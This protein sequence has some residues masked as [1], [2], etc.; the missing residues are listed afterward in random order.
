MKS[1]CYVLA[2]N[3]VLSAANPL[4][5]RNSS[6][7][8]QTQ[9]RKVKHTISRIFNI[10]NNQ[11]R[12][13]HDGVYYDQL[14]KMLTSESGGTLKLEERE[15]GTDLA[16]VDTLLNKIKGVY[17]ESE[18][19]NEIHIQTNK[20]VQTVDAESNIL[21]TKERK[22][23]ADI[24]N[25]IIQNLTAFNGS[26]LSGK[27]IR[28]GK[29]VIYYGQNENPSKNAI[30]INKNVGNS[31]LNFANIIRI[32]EAIHNLFIQHKV[33]EN[34]YY[35]VKARN[36]DAKDRIKNLIIAFVKF[37][38]SEGQLNS[39]IINKVKIMI[40]DNNIDI[41]L[42]KLLIKSNAD[43]GVIDLD[44]EPPT[45]AV[46]GVMKNIF[47]DSD[48]DSENNGQ[49]SDVTR[50]LDFA[51]INELKPG[52][53][54]PT[55]NLSVN[56]K[57]F[58][59]PT[60]ASKSLNT[61]RDNVHKDDSQEIIITKEGNSKLLIPSEVNTKDDVN[62]MDSNVTSN[63]NID[64][65]QKSTSDS[66]LGTILDYNLA[67]SKQDNRNHL[68][69]VGLQ[70]VK[71]P[72][73]SN[74]KDMTT[75]KD[76]LN[77]KKI[78]N[79]SLKTKVDFETLKTIL[80]KVM[81]NNIPFLQQVDPNVPVFSNI[82]VEEYLNY[83]NGKPF[84][85]YV[86]FPESE[87]SKISD[88]VHDSLIPTEK[89]NFYE[90][91]DGIKAIIRN[92]FE[93]YNSTPELSGEND[94]NSILHVIKDEIA[95]KKVEQD[96]KE[97][98]Q[99]T[100][101][102]ISPDI[103][104]DIIGKS[105]KTIGRHGQNKMQHPE[106]TEKEVIEY[107]IKKIYDTKMG[108]NKLN[109]QD[110]LDITE[111]ITQET[112]TDQQKKENDIYKQLLILFR[113]IGHST[114]GK[115]MEKDM[116]EK[117]KELLLKLKHSPD[118]DNTR[119]ITKDPNFFQKYLQAIA[120]HKSS[121]NEMDMTSEQERIYNLAEELVARL[122]YLQIELEK[123]NIS[124]QTQRELIKKEVEEEILKI[125]SDI[126]ASCVE[127]ANKLVELSIEKVLRKSIG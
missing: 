11:A 33:P 60:I 81:G 41:D 40:A 97:T 30:E 14:M 115:G 13:V 29:L 98:N 88:P 117:L 22:L 65:A 107:I 85:I 96:I 25:E 5:A 104:I 80:N 109:N 125:N 79:H 12:T 36:V 15:T 70:V 51:V 116:F 9:S 20:N 126:I 28:N 77:K 120:K 53:E 75:S 31:R 45:N 44:T 93:S 57:V 62:A 67:K 91:A 66:V 55:V 89:D 87:K 69:A 39:D 52:K 7:E 54:T 122:K 121:A 95:N 101:D 110:N 26:N 16:D 8:S 112:D 61:L 17:P 43:V 127:R 3:V 72:I 59:D 103:I 35:A 86:V 48:V 111:T 102:N 58:T 114:I 64:E 34:I 2:I 19:Q 100:P 99:G 21:G 27:Q 4:D 18:S 84:L 108:E 47:V 10:P 37:I 78:Q 124:R 118:D 32:E 113:N 1:L 68:K 119:S 46:S 83:N 63:K 6:D 73:S 82:P 23:N 56:A 90:V 105:Q 123:R 92:Y 38:A 71:D 50:T 74:I 106:N 49:I 76:I 42:G 24:L 94:L